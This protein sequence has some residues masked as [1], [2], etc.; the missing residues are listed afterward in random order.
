MIIKA[1]PPLFLLPLLKACSVSF[2]VPP[3]ME[4]PQPLWKTCAN[5]WSPLQQYFF[6][7]FKW[8]FLYFSV[9]QL[10][11]VFSVGTTTVPACGLST[12]GSSFP[13]FEF[14]K[15]LVVSF[16]HHVKVSQK[17]TKTIWC[18]YHSCWY[19]ANLLMVQSALLS[20]SL[21]KN[22]HMFQMLIAFI[23]CKLIFSFE[24]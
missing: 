13:F 5:V 2:W 22:S 23:H 6:L 19:C 3:Q 24:P 20:R 8:N 7:M 15:F 1:N 16:L 18:I 21:M 17:D 11:L 12:L 9:C 10:P 4:T 14:P